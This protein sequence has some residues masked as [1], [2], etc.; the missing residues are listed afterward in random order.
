LL[1]S[2]SCRW[3]SNRCHRAAIVGGLAYAGRRAHRIPQVRRRSHPG[4]E[5]LQE[6]SNTIEEARGKTT[7]IA[8]KL[9]EVEGL[10]ENEADRLLTGEESGRLFEDDVARPPSQ[11]SAP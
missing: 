11:A 5:K 2:T 1:C 4:A 6:A 10:P 7:T 9:R 3:D 8:R